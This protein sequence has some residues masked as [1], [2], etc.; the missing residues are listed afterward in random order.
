MRTKE[1]LKKYHKE[2][3]KKNKQKFFGL[4]QLACRLKRQYSL[5]VED[6]MLLYN[7][8]KEKCAICKCHLDLPERRGSKNTT[9]HIDHCHIT[10]KVRGLLCNKCNT[11]LGNFNDSRDLLYAAKEYLK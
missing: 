5:S 7:K 8:Q 1:E 11:G 9:A 4:S 2:Y 6:F 3:Y 10:L